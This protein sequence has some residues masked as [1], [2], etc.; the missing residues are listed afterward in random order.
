MALCRM[1]IEFLQQQFDTVEVAR[2]H[3]RQPTDARPWDVGFEPEP[4]TSQ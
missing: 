4:R 2:G 1:D 3:D